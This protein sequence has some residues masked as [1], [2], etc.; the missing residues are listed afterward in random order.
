MKLKTVTSVSVIALTALSLAAFGNPSNNVDAAA[1][2]TA[3]A[4]LKSGK[5]KLVETGY[6]HGYKVKM[7]IT[8]KKGKI[9]KTT[10]DYVNKKGKSKTKDKAYEIGEEFNEKWE[11][12]Q[13]VSFLE[14][15]GI[16]A[17]N[18]KK[19]YDALGVNAVEKIQENPYCLVDIVYGINF[20]KISYSVD[21]SS[22][23]NKNAFRVLNNNESLTN[24][25]IL[26]YEDNYVLVSTEEEVI[27]NINDIDIK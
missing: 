10:Y 3:G 6:S 19:V 17:N 24:K 20:N 8:V 5:Y 1:K 16:G 13:I 15:F 11:V 7:G 14:Q 12:W 21:S 4:K 25:D 18:S 22:N 27:N 23:L 2:Q 9:T 26:L